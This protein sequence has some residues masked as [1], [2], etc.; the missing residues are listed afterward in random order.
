MLAQEVE[1]DLAKK[2]KCINTHLFAHMELCCGDLY[3]RINETTHCIEAVQAVCASPNPPKGTSKMFASAAVVMYR[4]VRANGGD[5]CWNGSL[6]KLIESAAI[7]KY[8]HINPPRVPRRI[9]HRIVAESLCDTCRGSDFYDFKYCDNCRT[10]NNMPAFDISRELVL[11][12]RK[13]LSYMTR[14]VFIRMPPMHAFESFA[15]A[16]PHTVHTLC[17]PVCVRSDVQSRAREIVKLTLHEWLKRPTPHVVAIAAIGV[18][19]QEIGHKWS[20]GELT[21]AANCSELALK[22]AICTIQSSNI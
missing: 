7:L 14:H 3:T 19:L 18:V 9:P 15:V 4:S 10:A 16:I 8:I 22:R 13:F 11:F 5:S 12:S 20:V 1:C 21:E 17:V 6:D 2:V